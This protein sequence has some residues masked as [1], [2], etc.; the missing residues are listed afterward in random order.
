MTTYVARAR[1]WERGWELHIAGVGVTQ[2]RRLA[3]AEQQSR[4]FIST[5]SGRSAKNDEIELEFDLDDLG[6]R[7]RQARIATQN[8]AALQQDA[9][10]QIR[11]VVTDLRKEGFCVADIA[12]ILGVSN[13]R[14]SQL[15]SGTHSHR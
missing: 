7:A 2:V 6:E 15:A 3:D 4:D 10:V 12:T 5:I 8:A 9:A 1:R 11:A 13:G 14:V